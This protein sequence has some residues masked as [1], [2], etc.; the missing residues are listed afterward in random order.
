[1]R[2]K[3]TRIRMTIAKRDER[4]NARYVQANSRLFR[5]IPQSPTP[6]LSYDTCNTGWHFI[7]AIYKTTVPLLGPSLP[8]A[9][10]EIAGPRRK[11]LL[12]RTSLRR[13]RVIRLSSEIALFILKKRKKERWFLWNRA[14]EKNFSFRQKRD[15]WCARHLTYSR[16]TTRE[17][18][19][20]ENEIRK[21]IDYFK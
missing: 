16:F 18:Y 3:C 2:S 19:R 4:R 6:F 8:R 14:S 13:S 9:E 21:I 7:V 20:D 5:G 11:Y 17:R 10:L 1:M 12:G 15:R